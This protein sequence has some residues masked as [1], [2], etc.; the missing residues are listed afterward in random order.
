VFDRGR[1]DTIDSDEVVGAAAAI[2]AAVESAARGLGRSGGRMRS[3]SDQR[4]ISATDGYFK[5]T[6]YAG[7]KMLYWGGK[8]P[9]VA[10]SALSGASGVAGS[11]GGGGSG[12]FVLTPINSF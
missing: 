2:T 5:N 10:G 4:L 12:G 9:A 6:A 8:R 1:I 7:M 11:G 3:D